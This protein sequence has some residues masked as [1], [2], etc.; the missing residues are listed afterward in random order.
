M[1]HMNSGR[2]VSSLILDDSLKMGI[3]VGIGSVAV[4][5]LSA[6]GIEWLKVHCFDVPENEKK[7]SEKAIRGGHRR[8]RTQGSRRRKRRNDLVKLLAS[9]LDLP[10]STLFQRHNVDPWRTRS[11]GLDR[12]LEPLEFAAALLHIVK[13]RGYRSN[14]KA[15]ASEATKA[16]S[17]AGKV[18]AG[19]AAIKDKM[20][21]YRTLGDMFYRH[22]EFEGRKRNRASE[23]TRTVAREDTK[24]EVKELFK[25]Q[26]DLEN[27]LATEALQQAFTDIAYFQRP[28]KSSRDKVGTCPFVTGRPRAARCSPSF[29]RFRYLTRLKALTLVEG[30][31]S[32]PRPLTA[33]EFDRAAA[34]CG[35]KKSIRFADLRKAL[36]L[37]D[38]LSFAGVPRQ[39][40]Q[41]G[42]LWEGADIADRKRGAFVG[43]RALIDALAALLS[44]LECQRLVAEPGPLDAIAF[45]ITYCEEIRSEAHPWLKEKE[46]QSLEFRLTQLVLPDGWAEEFLDAALAGKFPDKVFKGVGHVSVEAAKALNRHLE[47]GATYAEA[48]T[49][50]GWDHAAPE[51]VSVEEI[52]NPVVANALRRSM[53]LVRAVISE[54]GRRPGRISIEMAREV[55]KAADVRSKIH[56]AQGERE[57]ER[58]KL[59]EE[60]RKEIGSEPMGEDLLA[61]ELWKLQE[62][63]CIYSR[64]YIDPRDLVLSRKKVEIDHVLPRSRSLDNSFV[65]KVLCLTEMNQVKGARTPYEWLARDGGHRRALDWET[66]EAW[67]ESLKGFKNLTKRNLTLRHFDDM[68]DR[69]I[70]RNLKDTQYICRAFRSQIEQEVYG[71]P[72]ARGELR[73]VFTRPGTLVGILRKAWGLNGLKYGRDGGRLGDRHHAVDATVVAAF[74]DDESLT[75]E[76]T[77]L[78][79]EWESGN[80]G[81]EE[82]DR[83]KFRVQPKA[84][85]WPTFRDDLKTALENLFVVRLEKR[86]E[87][88]AAHD[89]TLRGIV[90]GPNEKGLYGTYVKKDVKKLRRMDDYKQ[91]PKMYDLGLEAS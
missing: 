79:Q 66:F 28:L 7:V 60:F 78:F 6:G 82:G 25:R 4:S 85:P 77:H 50:E 46:D 49:M 13:H 90:D 18:K 51:T 27:N 35:T 87:T 38:H 30:V 20:G 69:F 44:P 63:R 53:K 1:N 75:Q 71:G 19:I 34:L 80:L 8:A 43:T 11:E 64:E 33:D 15:E 26:R 74:G 68:Q 81:R 67:V 45:E 2:G 42:T 10:K 84:W 70:D 54:I 36:K 39:K 3:D 72:P 73:R 12:L 5:V 41:K 91:V 37:P 88:G 23:Y 89:A 16:N 56:K 76:L 86:K 62:H 24:F 55:G 21:A 59:A 22:P 65:N 31:R 9:A 61:F 17:E 83:R 47:S 40:P 29:E 57:K 32:K 48:C 52:T 14:S 58:D